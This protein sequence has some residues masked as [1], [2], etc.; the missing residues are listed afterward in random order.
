M[1]RPKKNRFQCYN[2]TELTKTDVRTLLDISKE[3]ANRYWQNAYELD[4]KVLGEWFDADTNTVRLES[5]L[6]VS[7]QNRKH[8]LEAIKNDAA[9][10]SVKE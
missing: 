6:R 5:V 1:S 8:L 10:I 7:G 3:K 4:K 9:E 2:A